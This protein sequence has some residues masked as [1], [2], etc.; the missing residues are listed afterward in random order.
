MFIHTNSH[1]Q[2]RTYTAALVRAAPEQNVFRSRVCP[3]ALLWWGP[4]RRGGDAVY[5]VSHL[6][7]ADL[8]SEPKRVA[9]SG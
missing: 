7:T 3:G 8:G 1:S 4:Q 9:G 5:G 6:S 2:A